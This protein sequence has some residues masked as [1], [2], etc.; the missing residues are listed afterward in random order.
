M[1]LD[2]GFNCFLFCRHDLQRAGLLFFVLPS[3]GTFK[4]MKMSIGCFF[5]Q[6]VG[7]CIFVL[8]KLF[9]D[10]GTGSVSQAFTDI[11]NG[12][13]EAVEYVLQRRIRSASN[14][15]IKITVPLRYLRVRFSDLS[16]FSHSLPLS[17]LTL[18]MAGSTTADTTL[19]ET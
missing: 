6:R 10:D 3:L 4:L 9:F 12:C 5:V 19:H 2:N 14:V 1:F 17:C 8:S 18:L 16:I 13:R 11:T 15:Y 7:F